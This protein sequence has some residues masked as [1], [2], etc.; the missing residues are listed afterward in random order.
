MK[1]WI[2]RQR[3]RQMRFVWFQGSGLCTECPE[4]WAE[5]GQDS[6]SQYFPYFLPVDR[7]FPSR[8]VIS[9]FGGCD[10]LC[11]H[12]APGAGQRFWPLGGHIPKFSDNP[13]I[14]GWQIPAFQP[15]Q[16]CPTLVKSSPEERSWER[17]GGAKQANLNPPD[18]TRL[19]MKNVLWHHSPKG[20]F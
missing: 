12:T 19:I 16:S 4:G 1:V 6:F 5:L 18:P 15:S 13:T 9:P 20:D 10:I 8:M 14:H 2:Q 7:S 11:A 17:P 3:I